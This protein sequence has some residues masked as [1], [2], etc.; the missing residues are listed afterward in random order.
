MAERRIQSSAPLFAQVET[1]APEKQLDL[2]ESLC[3]AGEVSN[4]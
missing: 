1:T 4:V 3:K 2:E